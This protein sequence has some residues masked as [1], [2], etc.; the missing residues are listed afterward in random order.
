MES[1]ND[2]I[3]LI[4]I[5]EVQYWNDMTIILRHPYLFYGDV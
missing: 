2:L 3:E 5:W 4:R 1:A